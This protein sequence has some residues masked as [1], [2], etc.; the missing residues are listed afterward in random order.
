MSSRRPCILE[1]G[2]R[3]EWQTH[4]PVN[5]ARGRPKISD[6]GTSVSLG[7]VWEFSPDYFATL[8]ASRSERLPAAQELY[9]RGIH[10]ATNTYECG[11]VAHPLTCGGPENNADIRTETS[12]NVGLSLRKA[13]G[14]ATFEVS[15][16]YNDV[17]NYIYAR[18]LDQFEEFRLIKYTQ[19]DARFTGVEAEATYRFTGN[20]SA[21]IFGDYVRARLRQGENLPRIP[22][23][24]IGTRLNAGVG[25]YRGELEYSRVDR[26]NDVADFELATP[27]Y[28]MLNLTLSYGATDG[29][30]LS[31]YLRGTNLLNELV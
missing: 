21:T 29:K 6:S 13:A 19:S 24:R 27:G 2:L 12:Q 9:A 7:A 16:F 20:F 28:N 18:T 31:V 15:G 17:D 26:Q 23:G 10:L 3:Q 4:E 1:A 30:G 22:A 5:D 8:T 11:M 25:S 14:D